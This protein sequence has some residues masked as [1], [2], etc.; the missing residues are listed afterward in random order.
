MAK[1]DPGCVENTCLDSSCER[2]FAP[3]N[4]QRFEDFVIDQKVLFQM[5][6]VTYATYVMSR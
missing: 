3:R 6:F 2:T 4:S 5:E 1:S